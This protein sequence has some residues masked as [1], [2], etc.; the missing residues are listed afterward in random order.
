MV[1]FHKDL[2]PKGILSNCDY[3]LVR[4]SIKDGVVKLLRTRKL[5]STRQRVKS[6]KNSKDERVRQSNN[7]ANSK[8]WTI[9]RA[10][11]ISRQFIA[12]GQLIAVRSRHSVNMEIT[13]YFFVFNFPERR[14]HGSFDAFISNFLKEKFILRS[15]LP[16]NLA[17][18]TFWTYCGWTPCCIPGS[19]G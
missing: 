6:I 10:W 12:L 7:F 17:I 9:F 13:N 15:T 3:N 4:K 19:T 1:W 5:L 14:C 8:L 11:L 18:I 16:C 2:D